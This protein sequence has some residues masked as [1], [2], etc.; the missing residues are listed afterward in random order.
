MTA[1][2]T[3]YQRVILLRYFRVLRDMQCGARIVLTQC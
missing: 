3:P 1:G 2:F